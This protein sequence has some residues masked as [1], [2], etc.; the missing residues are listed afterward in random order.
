MLVMID[1]NKKTVVE[2]K[3]MNEKRTES[4]LYSAYRQITYKHNI[5]N[6]LCLFFI[7]PRYEW[8]IKRAKTLNK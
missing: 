3:E 2:V 6:I 5:F 4:V 7:K 8:L 1:N